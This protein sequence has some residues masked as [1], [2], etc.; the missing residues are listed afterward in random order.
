MWAALTYAGLHDIPV[1]SWLL[2]E[3]MSRFAPLVDVRVDFRQRRWDEEWVNFAFGPGEEPVITN[4]DRQERDAEY[5]TRVDWRIIAIWDL[6][7]ILYDSTEATIQSTGKSLHD[8]RLDLARRVVGILMQRRSLQMRAA[9]DDNNLSRSV[10][11]QL[12]IEELTALLDGLTGG[13]F[14]ATSA[15]KSRRSA[16]LEPLINTTT[17]L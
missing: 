5:Y 3:K 10:Q 4:I 17:N 16:D 2:Q 15:A 12:Q 7:E 14:S 9:R 1:D 11:L 6:G 13:Y 8:D